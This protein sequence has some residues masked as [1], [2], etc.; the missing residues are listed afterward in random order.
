MTEKLKTLMHEQAE[1]VQFEAPNLDAMIRTGDRTLRRRRSVALVGGVA[2]AAV[3]L[4]AGGAL[5]PGG[6][7]PDGQGAEST[8]SPAPVTW[9]T[10]STLHVGADRSV[11]LGPAVRSYV[12]TAEGYVL[13]DHDGTVWSWQDGRAREVGRVD[14]R[15]PHLVSDDETG[16]ASWIDTSAPSPRVVVLDQQDGTSTDFAVDEAAVP[17]HLV[18]IDDGAVYLFDGRGLVSVRLSTGGVTAVT[19]SPQLGSRVIDVED[20][21]FASVTGTGSVV[22][23]EPGDG[24][25]LEGAYGQVG[26][27]SPGGRY[28]SSEGDEQAVFDTATGARV[29]LDLDQRFATGYEWLDESTL[30]VLAADRPATGA[31]AQLLTCTVPDGACSVVED[32]LGSFAELEGHFALPTGEYAG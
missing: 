26:T 31:T 25:P 21:T 24:V 11:D 5:L 23:A 22:G 30:A 17:A 15:S 8:A 14:R 28:F 1:A 20:G 4:V 3:A 10:G 16:L 32:D 29:T 18:T 9:V 6:D 19:A 2:A 13:A 12:R 7:R 27:L